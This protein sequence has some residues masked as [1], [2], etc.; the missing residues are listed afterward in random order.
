MEIQGGA[1]A[2]SYMRKG[3]LIY[4]GM[5]KYLVIYEEAVSHIW[6]CN[7][8]IPNFLIFEGNLIFFFISMPVRFCLRFFNTHEMVW[9]EKF[10]KNSNLLMRCWNFK[11]CSG[12]ITATL[13]INMVFFSVPLCFW[14]SLRRGV[15]C[16]MCFVADW[17][18]GG[19][20]GGG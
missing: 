6:L 11:R 8:S 15:D 7:W 17:T 13:Q 1:V 5:R 9:L 20:G 16:L 2:Q 10:N 14:S 12:N 18:S 19:G 3:V 4:E